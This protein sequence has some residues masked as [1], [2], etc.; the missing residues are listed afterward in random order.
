VAWLTGGALLVGAFGGAAAAWWAMAPPEPTAVD[1]PA[2]PATEE[3][4]VEADLRERRAT[5]PDPTVAEEDVEDAPAPI[6]EAEP[7]IVT[8]PS[9]AELLARANEARRDGE[10][11]GAV[12]RYR[13][14]QSMYPRSPEA[15]L[16]H[17]ALGRL[18]LDRLDDPG[19]ALSQFDRYLTAPG[20]LAEE[21]RVGRALALMRLGRPAEER[22]AWQDLLDHHPSSPHADRARARIE[23]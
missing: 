15:Q 8:R 9:A 18:F 23:P 6:P 1:A 20:T 10:A 17:V 4:G 11:R 19:A 13:E 14:L 2:S 5:D 22:R 16:S 3:P 7:P 12:R 21:A